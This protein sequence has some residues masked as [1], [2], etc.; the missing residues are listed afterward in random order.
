MLVLLHVKSM[1]T[2]LR[3]IFLSNI[4]KVERLGL[5]R[6][7]SLL[8]IKKIAERQKGELEKVSVIRT[9][10]LRECPLAEN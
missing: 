6:T 3:I 9:V 5:S 8:F 10:G 4:S 1:A 2:F 7:L